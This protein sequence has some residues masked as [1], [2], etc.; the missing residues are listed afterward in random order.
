MVTI[1]FHYKIPNILKHIPFLGFQLYR[2]QNS[3][4]FSYL[5]ALKKNTKYDFD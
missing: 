4:S 5:C 2:F 3:Y 1:D